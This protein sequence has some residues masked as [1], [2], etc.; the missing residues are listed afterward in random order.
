METS[1]HT[2]LREVHAS[3]TLSTGKSWVNLQNVE[4]EFIEVQIFDTEHA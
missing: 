1:R 2:M 3:L 4:K